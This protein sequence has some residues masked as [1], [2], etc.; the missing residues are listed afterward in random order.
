MGITLSISW[1]STA[2]VLFILLMQLINGTKVLNIIFLLVLFTGASAAAVFGT[3][4][5]A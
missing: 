5:I 1:V 3:V 4:I 2:Y